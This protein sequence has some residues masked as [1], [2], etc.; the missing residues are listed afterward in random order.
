MDEEKQDKAGKVAKAMAKGS[1]YLF[2][3]SAAG[4]VIM[5][6]ASILIARFLGPEQYGVYSLT[7]VIPGLLTAF[8]DLGTNSALSK[9]LP[10]MRQDK[11]DDEI[12]GLIRS[13]LYFNAIISSLLFIPLFLFPGMFAQALLNRG[14]IDLYVR[15]SSFLIITQ[16]LSATSTNIFV[17]LDKTKY[18]A[19]TSIA[20]ASVKF[21]LAVLLVVSFG[22]FGAISG[23]VLSYVIGAILAIFFCLKVYT[24]H[25][26][27]NLNRGMSLNL[28]P[29][30]SYGLP[31]YS[32]TLLTV[33][34][35][36]YQQVVLAWYASNVEIG[37]YMVAVNFATFITILTGPINTMLLPSFSKLEKDESEMRGFLRYST[38]YALFIV[39]PMAFLVASASHDLVNL[40]YGLEYALAPSYLAI[41]SLTFS[42][43]IFWIILGNFFSG[44]GQVKIY[45]NATFVKFLSSLP[46]ALIFISQWKVMGLVASM[47]V[48]DFSS[49]VYI[50]YKAKTKYGVS[51]DPK[52]PLKIF[53]SSII[54]SLILF[55]FNMKFPIS[56]TILSLILNIII[57]A[58]SYIMVSMLMGTL[59]REDMD[60]LRLAFRE[61]PLRN[62]L[63]ELLSLY[64]K[65]A[66]SLG[67]L[68]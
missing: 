41:Y 68:G 64:E 43:M 14:D 5:T 54:S 49:I 61:T 24:I 27:S 15:I 22:I 45:L 66:S 26:G 21:V 46:L 36:R 20:Q 42:Y 63:E 16:A 48:S 65:I 4:T 9:F 33:V 56:I 2:I 58:L 10:R 44:I 31:L 11:R 39:A 40:F 1:L 47:F 53:F 35:T 29:M 50:Y 51:I 32:S 7:L 19:V 23:H 55:F 37:N 12:R 57:F 8:T 3:G 34:L 28:R 17:G 13:G 67:V 60:N 6:L 25:K 59:R 52:D 38:K 62:I 18:N 30:L